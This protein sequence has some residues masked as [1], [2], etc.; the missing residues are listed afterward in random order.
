M[1]QVRNAAGRVKRPRAISRAE[2]LDEASDPDL[3]AHCR[4]ELRPH[5]EDFLET[6]EREKATADHAQNRIGRGLP[7]S[8]DVS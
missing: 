3:R 4:G 2:Q 1:P 6:V 7:T 8:G 5:V